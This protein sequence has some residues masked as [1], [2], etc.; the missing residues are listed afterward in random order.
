MST[1][2]LGR[3]SCVYSQISPLNLNNC[4]S[5]GFDWSTLNSPA[6]DPAPWF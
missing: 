1:G 4:S 5:V 3:V 6:D 2:R